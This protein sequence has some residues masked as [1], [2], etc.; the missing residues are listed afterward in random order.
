MELAVR[1]Q[2][3]LLC[4]SKGPQV[5]ECDCH[6]MWGVWE[7]AGQEAITPVHRRALKRGT[8]STNGPPHPL[9]RTRTLSGRGG[10]V[11]VKNQNLRRQLKGDCQKPQLG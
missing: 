3:V 10:Y 4:A 11:P 2:P 6:S 7:R 1:Y 8:S 5:R 9:Y